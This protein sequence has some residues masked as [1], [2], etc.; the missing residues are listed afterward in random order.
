M[1]RVRG[2][3]AEDDR[4][5]LKQCLRIIAEATS[6]EDLGGPGSEICTDGV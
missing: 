6:A 4:S 1:F 2:R 5:N 3:F